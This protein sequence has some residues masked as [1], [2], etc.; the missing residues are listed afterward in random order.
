MKNPTC[1]SC[2]NVNLFGVETE[3]CSSTGRME[4]NE[5]IM[6]AAL[7]ESM[8]EVRVLGTVEVDKLSIGPREIGI[9]KENRLHNYHQLNPTSIGHLFIYVYC[10]YTL[11]FSNCFLILIAVYLTF[12]N[13]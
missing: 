5:S 6:D 13:R 11:I 10:I 3:N 4:S 12:I 1:S 7:G 8:E 2:N 9:L